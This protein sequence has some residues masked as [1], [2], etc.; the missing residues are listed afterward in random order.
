MIASP[1]LLE[2]VLRWA[3]DGVV[4]SALA[5]LS[6]LLLVWREVRAEPRR[7]AALLTGIVAV[8]VALRLALPSVHALGAWPFTRLDPWAAAIYEGPALAQLGRVFGQDVPLTEVMFGTSLFF[9]VLTPLLVFLHARI[10]LGDSSRALVAALAFATLPM[11]IRFTA[12]EVEF[13]GSTATSSFAFILLHIALR[14]RDSL[15]GIGAFLA[16]PFVMSGLMHLRPL[17]VLFIPVF[18]SFA[19][20][21][22]PASTPAD[23]KHRRTVALLVTLAGA[24]GAYVSLSTHY[25]TQ[26]REG[27]SLMTLLSAVGL[28][29]N[30]ISNSLLN[31]F[32]TPTLYLVASVVG[33]VL[34]WRNDRRLGVLLVG[35]LLLFHTAHAFVIAVVPE[36]QARYYLHMVVPFSL[37]IGC[38]TPALQRLRPSLRAA[39]MVYVVAV[40]AL[41]LGFIRDYDFNDAREFAFLRDHRDDIPPDCTVLEF[42]GHDGSNVGDR[43]PRMAARLHGGQS[44]V[45]FRSMGFGALL[46]QRDDWSVA[47]R[48]PRYLQQLPSGAE[49]AEALIT[50]EARALMANPPACLYVYTG[51]LCHTF[52]Q[53]SQP[54]APACARLLELADTE[55]V[56]E[57]HFPSRMYDDNLSGGIAGEGAPISLGLYRVV[58]P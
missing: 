54:I 45:R 49:T 16:L 7:T 18:V 26:V 23:A 28:L 29:L 1:A 53:R 55:P 58:S 5:T 33:A 31:P 42:T 46:G 44:E 13:I 21:L 43:M 11:H 51:L 38:A 37:L 12:S 17:N 30:P 8:G 24:Y 48:D 40:P 2:E 39:A 50:P 32:I 3:C 56:A 57:S 19:L 25:G 6:L 41:H 4:L 20:W 52:K 22:R 34:C 35:W 14:E 36:M 9:G 27:L 47:W 15:W 10:L